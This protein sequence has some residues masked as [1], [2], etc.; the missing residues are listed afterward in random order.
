MSP[1]NPRFGKNVNQLSVISY[2]LS[3]I[4][5]QLSV[6]SYQLS[7]ISYQLSVHRLLFTAKN[8]PIYN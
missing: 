6:I 4:S 3:V 8:Y 7:V 1:G 5:N 2:Q